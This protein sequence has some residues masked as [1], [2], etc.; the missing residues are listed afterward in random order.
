MGAKLVKYFDDA[1]AVGGYKARMRMAMITL[2]SSE[3]AENAD[4]SPDN[5]E[6]FEKALTEIK[7][8]FN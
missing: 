3:K 7:K 5:V 4:D 2:M 1:E 8:E 6:K